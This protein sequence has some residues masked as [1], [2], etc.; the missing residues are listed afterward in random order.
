MALSISD[1]IFLMI[2]FIFSRKEDLQSRKKYL[3][4]SK[5]IK[6]SLTETEIMRDA[7]V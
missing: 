7:F 1:L 4:E 3:E 2:N 5:E 6:H